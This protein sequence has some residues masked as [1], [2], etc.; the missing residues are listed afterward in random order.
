MSQTGEVLSMTTT[1]HRSPYYDQYGNV[2]G[3]HHC[4]VIHTNNYGGDDTSS[5]ASYSTNTS[6]QESY[7]G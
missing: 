3:Y 1:A 4:P 2:E 5:E 7:Y 6:Y